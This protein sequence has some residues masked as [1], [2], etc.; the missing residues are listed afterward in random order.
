VCYISALIA[1]L[2]EGMQV[3][4][5]LLVPLIIGFIYSVKISK[6]LPRLKEIMGVKN[7]AVAF[8]WAFTGSLLPALIVTVGTKEVILVFIYIFIQLF[9]NTV[10]FDI[11][12]MAGDNA[13]GVKTIPLRFKTKKNIRYF[14]LIINSLLLI[15]LIFCLI[16]NTFTKYLPVTIFGVLYSYVTIYHFTTDKKPN[17]LLAEIL[18]D[19]Q[20]IPIVVFMWLLIMY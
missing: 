20:W 11:I 10:L 18:I 12:D 9:I 14:L 2:T 6:S 5:V 4:L 7:V 17:R 19:G 1:G 3:V 15:W 16:S 8:S 13:A